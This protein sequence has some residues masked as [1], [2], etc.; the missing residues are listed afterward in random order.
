METYIKVY[1]NIF[2]TVSALLFILISIYY[3]LPNNYELFTYA[4]DNLFNKVRKIEI[5]DDYIDYDEINGYYIKFNEESNIILDNRIKSDS[6]IIKKNYYMIVYNDCN[7]YINNKNKDNNK[8]KKEITLYLL[9][10]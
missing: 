2:I 8:N 3:I 10:K 5:K 6:I 4:D 9:K 7:I 1:V